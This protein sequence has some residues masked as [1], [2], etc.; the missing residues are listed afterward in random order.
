[1]GVVLTVAVE[2]GGELFGIKNGQ[3]KTPEREVRGY[4]KCQTSLASHGRE[5]NYCGS[6]STDTTSPLWFLV[7]VI[8]HFFV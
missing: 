1:M 7:T 2:S 6:S 8:F 4:S 3:T 5:M